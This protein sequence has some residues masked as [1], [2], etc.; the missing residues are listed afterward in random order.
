M[1]I[2]VGLGRGFPYTRAMRIH[3]A[4]F[5]LFSLVSIAC[6]Q[7]ADTLRG[8]DVPDDRTTTLVRRT[9]TGRL[10]RLR[11]RPEIAAIQGL[12]LDPATAELAREII[13]ARTRNISMMLVDDIELVGEITVKNGAGDEAGARAVFNG[14]WERFD[15]GTPRAPLMDPLSGVLDAAQRAELRGLVDEYWDAWID[16]E[17]RKNKNREKPATRQ[18]AERRLARQLF[19]REVREAYD[20]SLKRYQQA[21]EGIFAAIEPTDE[22]RVEIRNIVIDHIKATR[23]SATSAQRREANMTIY[24]LLDDERK[25]RFFGYMSA[26]V[27]PD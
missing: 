8:P 5:C 20:V 3:L 10:E 14:L 27:I 19:Q 18:R 24:R 2:S 15:P 17:L 4:A 21:L 23:L 26:I 16:W 22:Q 1:K 13:D 7:P 6:G 9:M 11:V 12:H 25:E